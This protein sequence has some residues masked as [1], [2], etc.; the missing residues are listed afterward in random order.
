METE[1]ASKQLNCYFKGVQLK[2]AI[3]EGA[4]RV[5]GVI[6]VIGEEGEDWKAALAAAGDSDDAAPTKAEAPKEEAPPVPQA[7]AP[8]AAPDPVAAAALAPAASVA[9]RADVLQASPLAH[10][11]T[12]AAGIYL[13]LTHL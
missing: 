2:I 13:S 1:K 8:V 11:M 4:V 12:N 5:D 3:K 6:A 9:S 10:A 7:A